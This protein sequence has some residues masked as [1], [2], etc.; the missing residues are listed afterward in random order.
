VRPVRLGVEVL[1]AFAEHAP[2]AFGWR[3][4][5]YEFVTDR[6]A[7][8]L[9]AGEETLRGAIDSGTGIAEWIASWPA[10]EERFLVERAP[11]LL[12]D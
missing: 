7:I 2:D 9:L 5:A 1:A 3:H 11:A 10:D 6:P 8:D 4:E 12:Y